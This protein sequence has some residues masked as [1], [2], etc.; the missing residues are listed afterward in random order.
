VVSLSQDFLTDCPEDRPEQRTAPDGWPV[1]GLRDRCHGGSRGPGESDG[2][3]LLHHGAA[4]ARGL[5]I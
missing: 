5:L 3:R 4:D 1:D 2:A